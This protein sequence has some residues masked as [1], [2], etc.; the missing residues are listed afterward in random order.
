V[1]VRQLPIA[2]TSYTDSLGTGVYQWSVRTTDA[3]G[4]GTTSASRTLTVQ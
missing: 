1:L 2:G 4:N 3:A